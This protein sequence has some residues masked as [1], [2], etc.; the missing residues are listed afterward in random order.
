MRAQ[1][2]G[3]KCPDQ[4]GSGKAPE[5]LRAPASPKSIAN[6]HGLL[7]CIFQAAVEAEPQLR[8]T[9]PCARTRL[10]RTDDHTVEEMCFLEREEYARISTE[11]RA[12]EPAAADLTDF[13]VGTGLRWGEATALQTRDVNL[14]AATPSVQRAW[15]RQPDNTFEIGPPKT[16]KGRR[17]LALSPSQVELL[18]PLLAGRGPEQYVFRGRDGGRQGAVLP[19]RAVPLCR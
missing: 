3:I 9:N 6:R 16:R 13:L 17:V 1:E 15:K 5:W 11:L 19:S 4:Q 10:P 14:A 7:F 2:K 8:T 12:I 18:R